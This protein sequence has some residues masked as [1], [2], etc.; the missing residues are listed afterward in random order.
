MALSVRISGDRRAT[1]LCRHVPFSW[2]TTRSQ[3]TLRAVIIAFIVSPSFKLSLLRVRH[4]HLALSYYP[5]PEIKKVNWGSP[6]QHEQ[7]RTHWRLLITSVLC[8]GRMMMPSP[9][10]S[11]NMFHWTSDR[12]AVHCSHQL[13]AMQTWQALLFYPYLSLVPPPASRWME[14][15]V[16][17]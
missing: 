15:A 7:T 2:S 16:L 10:S 6:T 5:S 1:T 14:R 17:C 9:A 13:N 11:I 12:R 4:L 8:D 3:G